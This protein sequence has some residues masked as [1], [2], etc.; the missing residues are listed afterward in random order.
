MSFKISQ[1]ALRDFYDDEVCQIKWEENYVNG[2]RSQPTAAMLD[3]LV[4]EQ[5]VIG[6]SRG[7]E[8][9]EIPKG[10]TGKP[11][12]RET[13]LLKLAAESKRQWKI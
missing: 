9:Y 6:L 11:L 7:G 2:Y 8:V 1:S 10:K 12:K 3:G 5:N 13:D 4:F